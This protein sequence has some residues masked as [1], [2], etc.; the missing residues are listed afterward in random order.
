MA[1]K[2]K[3][4][5]HWSPDIDADGILW[6]RLDVAGKSTNILSSE[7]LEEFG[8]II[9]EVEASLP[10]GLVITSAKANGFIAGA[11]IDEFIE[12]KDSEEA[13][14]NITRVHELFNRLENLACPTLSL[15]NGFCLGGGLELSLACRYRVALDDVKTR[16]GLPE[17]LLGIHPGFGGLMR[18]LRQSGPLEGIPLM[19]A[20]RTLDARKAKKAGLVDKVVAERQLERTARLM[21]QQQPAVKPLARWKTLANLTLLRPLLAKYMRSQ[22]RKKAREEH[23]PAPFA[24]I[25]VWEKYGGNEKE[26]LR[27]EAESVARLCVTDTSRNLVRLFKLQDRL[28][29][30]NPAVD[31]KAKHVHVIGAGVMGGDIAAWCALQGMR[32]T[33]QDREAK[34]IAPA[35]KRAHKLFKRKLKQTRLITA[36]MDRL[37]PDVRGEGVENADIIIEAIIENADAKISLFKDLEGKAKDTSILATN[38]SSIPLHE[39][40]AGL[41]KPERL[42]GVHFF[43]PVAQMQLVEIVHDTSTAKEWIHK[44]EAFCQQISRLPVAVASSPGFLV[45]RILTPYLLEAVKLWEEG[46]SAEEIDNVAKK[47][48]MPMGPV[49]LADTVGLDICLSVSGNMAETLNISVPDKL[50]QM[51]E[52]GNLGKKSGKGFYDYEKGKIKRNKNNE[53]SGLADM[54]DRMV[55]RI[56]NECIACLREEIV[57]DKDLLDAGMVFGTGFAPFRGGPLHYAQ[58]RD[59]DDTVATLENLSDKYGE[60]FQPDAG[61]T[62]LK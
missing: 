27:A 34:F 46:A 47:F 52:Q 55:M 61:W 23:Y 58:S 36:A 38:T 7:V 60:R 37:M 41:K 2:A 32:V 40:S 26:L 20:G 35:I 50:K 21:I 15:I 59:I 4:Y 62:L 22:L 10:L 24:I 12:I 56:L 19:L 9:D 45:N 42:V 5:K 43:N 3:K 30:K 11:N 54:E 29:S 16:I 48:G 49:E 25:D 13:L 33:L 51:V 28:K 18:M 6:C 17:V 31:Y 39:I 44:A 1:K 57:E 53:P 14:E 8:G